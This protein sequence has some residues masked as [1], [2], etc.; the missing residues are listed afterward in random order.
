MDRF[1]TFQPDVL[2]LNIGL[3]NG[4][5]F[6]LVDWLRLHNRLDR[7][8]ILA[9]S[10]RDLS[11]ADFRVPV[12]PNQLLV[13]G[14]IQPNQLEAL[15]LTMLRTSLPVEDPVPPESTVHKP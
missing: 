10:S 4:D 6:N 13:R 1:F 9:Y 8:P 7:L 2:M 5:S 12:T 11:V 14:R 15:V 3:T